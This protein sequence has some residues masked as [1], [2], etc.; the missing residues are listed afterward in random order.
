MPWPWIPGQPGGALSYAYK[1]VEAGKGAHISARRPMLTQ[2]LETSANT[3]ADIGAK[4]GA[5]KSA[6]LREGSPKLAPTQALT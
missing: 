2:A 6:N 4:I 1:V 5:D 3:S